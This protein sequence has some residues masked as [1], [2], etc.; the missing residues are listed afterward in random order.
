MIKIL[1]A[2]EKIMIRLAMDDLEKFTCVKFIPRTEEVDYLD[3]IS[4][5][6][7]HSRVGKIGGKQDV[8]LQ[9]GGCFSR[10]T[11]IH[12]LV[13]SLGYDHMQNHAERDKFVR[14]KWENIRPSEAHN[15]DKVNPKKYSNFGT[16][17][18]EI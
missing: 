13:H 8:S 5:R 11:I 3:I 15:F 6:G 14:I 2:Y 10:G 16:T 1:A 7:C 9:K 12:E 4:D 18:G 17:Y